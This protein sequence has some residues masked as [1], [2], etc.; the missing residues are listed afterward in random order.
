MRYDANENS[1]THL[2]S[3]M[4]PASSSLKFLEWPKQQR[5]H[6]DHYSQSKYSRWA[7]SESVVT[8]AEYNK[9]VFKWRRKVDRDRAE[10]TSSGKLFQTLAPA[11]GKA[12]LQRILVKIIL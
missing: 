7:E 5:H 4:K 10:V 8:A 6:E 2:M 3:R 9:Y 11:I 1:E 12:R